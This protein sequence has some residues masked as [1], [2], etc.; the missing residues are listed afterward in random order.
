MA[1]LTGNKLVL[2]GALLLAVLGGYALF[3]ETPK[4]SGDVITVYKSPT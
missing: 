4:A 2:I 3:S 1:A